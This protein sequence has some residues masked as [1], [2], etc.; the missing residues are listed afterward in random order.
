MWT[1]WITIPPQDL[2]E[3]WGR[4][5]LKFTVWS[6]LVDDYRITEVNHDNIPILTSCPYLSPDL[7]ISLAWIDYD[8]LSPH[9]YFLNR[10]MID[11]LKTDIIFSHWS[12]LIIIDHHWSSLTINILLSSTIYMYVSYLFYH[13]LFQ[14]IG[15][16]ENLQPS[17]QVFPVSGAVY[18]RCL[19]DRCTMALFPP[20]VAPSSER[21]WLSFCIPWC[22]LVWASRLLPVVWRMWSQTALLYR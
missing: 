20:R 14:W 11:K 13:K 5:W 7:P 18:N 16:R 15:L 10:Q 2:E 6:C 12:S 4:V 19:G 9:R 3:G 8:I 1:S 21:R 22:Y 17:A